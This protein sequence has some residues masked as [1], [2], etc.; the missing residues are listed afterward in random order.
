ME[1]ALLLSGRF[2]LPGKEALTDAVTVFTAV[3]V[4]VSEVPC[5]RPKKEGRPPTGAVLRKTAT[6]LVQ[7]EKEAPHAEIAAFD[8]F[9]HHSDPLSRSRP[10]GDA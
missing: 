10:W 4:E 5:E 6:G 1:D 2:S 9:S 8:P 3:V 7:R